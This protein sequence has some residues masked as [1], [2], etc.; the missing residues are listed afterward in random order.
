[1]SST[2]A[3]RTLHSEPALGADFIT[4][5]NQTTIIASEIMCARAKGEPIE[6]WDITQNLFFFVNRRG[7][8]SPDGPGVVLQRV[9]KR[10][11][12]PVCSVPGNS[13]ERR[14]IL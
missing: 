8:H 6:R 13:L 3:I 14:F 9:D 10:P 5:A 7:R 12:C 2:N 1:M 4:L 11:G